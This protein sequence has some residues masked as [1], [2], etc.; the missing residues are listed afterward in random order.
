MRGKAE[1]VE[2]NKKLEKVSSCFIGVIN[3]ITEGKSWRIEI[4]I[5]AAIWQV[6]QMS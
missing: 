3:Q 1:G 6:W 2:E 4:S 5:A